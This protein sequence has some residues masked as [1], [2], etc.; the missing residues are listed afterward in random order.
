MRM[1]AENSI[2]PKEKTLAHDLR[3]GLS[4]DVYFCCGEDRIGCNKALLSSRSDVFKGMFENECE[5]AKTEEIKIS[6]VTFE[7]VEQLIEFVYENKCS[8]LDEFTE[9]LLFLG[10]EYDLQG[11]FILCEVEFK[12]KLKAENAVQLFKLAEKFNAINLTEEV[13]SFAKSNVDHVKETKD[14]KDLKRNGECDVIY[15]MLDL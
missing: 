9:E 2:I 15:K 4:K 14:W 8:K 6:E 1:K 13:K 11:L 10:H 5:G 7:A 3:D 12:K